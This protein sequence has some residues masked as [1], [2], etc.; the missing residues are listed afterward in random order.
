MRKLLIISGIVIVLFVFLA[1]LENM[2]KPEA[3]QENEIS[4]EVLQK[5]ITEQKEQFVYFYQTD[6][7]YCKATSPIVI[8][9]A[10][11]M[12]VDLKQLNLQEETEGWEKFDIEGTPTIVHFKNG[13][14]VDRIFG[15]KTKEEF[16][17]WFER[18]S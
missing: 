11:E 2:Q 14:E 17:E 8:P 15:Q 6:C 18:N 5:N 4:I 7:I 13:Q 12:N 1:I 10:E 16:Q 3:N 9:L